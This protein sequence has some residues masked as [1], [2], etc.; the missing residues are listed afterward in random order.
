MARATIEAGTMHEFKGSDRCRAVYITGL[1]PDQK[2]QPG[3]F[4]ST[5]K[6]IL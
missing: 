3:N 5:P 6:L 1:Q 2:S 4:P